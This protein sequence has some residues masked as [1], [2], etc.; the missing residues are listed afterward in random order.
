M[1]RPFISVLVVDDYE[2]FRQYVCSA[3]RGREDIKIVGELADGKDAIKKAEELKPDL[4]V[5]D[6]GLPK[7]NGVEAARQIRR[8]SPGS[9]ILFLSQ[10]TSPEV[11]EMVL[12]LGARGY[13]VKMDAANELLS[14]VDAVLRG[15]RFIG[16]RLANSDLR[17]ST[18][19]SEDF[20]CIPNETRR[21]SKAISR[22]HEAG[23]YSDDAS[24]IDAFSEFI[25]SALIDEGAVIV[26][27]TVSHHQELLKRLAAMGVAVAGAVKQGR[28]IPLEVTATLSTFMHNGSLDRI[29]FC[30]VA[31]DLVD[32]AAKAVTNG[33]R[34]SAC[35]ECAPVLGLQG[36]FKAMLQLEELWDELARERDVNLLCG[37]LLASFQGEPGRQDLRQ[38][39]KWHSAVYSE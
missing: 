19:P 37:Y 27:A 13:V 34:V 6:I 15:E 22:Y 10:E 35:G 16:N 5:L 26:V 24:L 3:L 30:N 14:A 31:N 1:N 7:V 9:R 17:A 23:F 4:I 28:Y 33:R 20:P 11:V 2:P 8:L 36:N 32:R 38:V 18:Q 39:A 12:N 21:Q 29:K 25:R